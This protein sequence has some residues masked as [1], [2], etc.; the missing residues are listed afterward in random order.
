MFPLSRISYPD[1]AR[2]SGFW[3]NY[4]NQTDA[5]NAT[6][7]YEFFSLIYEYEQVSMFCDKKSRV[8]V[9]VCTCLFHVLWYLDLPQL[10]G[11]REK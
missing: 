11:A 9:D 10:A 3:I 1:L 7:I 2:R 5:S 8:D 4:A 6:Q